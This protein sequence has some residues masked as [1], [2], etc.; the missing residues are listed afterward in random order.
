MIYF[1]SDDSRGC[2]NYGLRCKFIHEVRSISEINSGS[3][4]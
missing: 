4:Y 3:F 1:R 2:C